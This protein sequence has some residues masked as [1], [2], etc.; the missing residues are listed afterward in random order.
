MADSVLPVAESELPAVNECCNWAL[1]DHAI[2]FQD[3]TVLIETD[4]HVH[5][6]YDVSCELKWMDLLMY[7]T[8]Q[9]DALRTTLLIRSL[10]TVYLGCGPQLS[11]YW[12]DIERN[13]T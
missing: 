8:V 13:C 10:S 12:P 2:V 7:C 1:V 11:N 9:E 4:E 6:A 3:R 5:R